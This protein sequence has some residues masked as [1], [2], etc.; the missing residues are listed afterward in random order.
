MK[1]SASLFLIEKFSQKLQER[2][3]KKIIEIRLFGSKA[4]G[5]DH[6]GSDI[7]LL[8]VL[9]KKN[10]EAEDIIVDL[11]LEMMEKYDYEPYFSALVF[12]K[13]EFSRLNKLKTNFMLNVA[14]E[15]ITIWKS[16]EARRI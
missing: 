16:E 12:E 5:R 1:K 11:E 9:D 2:L 14:E 8:V 13:E 4:T 7:D 15:G 10:R 6:K 3:G